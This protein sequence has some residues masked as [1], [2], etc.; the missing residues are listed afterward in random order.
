MARR[1]KV[2]AIRSLPDHLL[3]YLFAW[4]R[5]PI[6][7]LADAFPLLAPYFFARYLHYMAAICLFGCVERG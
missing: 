5:E 7:R 2:G 3:R 1:G 4:F 6:L